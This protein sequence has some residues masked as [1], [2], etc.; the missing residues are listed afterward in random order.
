M[1][2]MASAAVCGF[3]MLAAMTQAFIVQPTLRSSTSSKLGLQQQVKLGVDI[4]RN[5]GKRSKK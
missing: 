3:L 4:G 5:V 1:R 2:T